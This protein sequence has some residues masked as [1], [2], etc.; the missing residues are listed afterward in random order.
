MVRKKR[1][2]ASGQLVKILLD[3]QEIAKLGVG[4]MERVSISPGSHKIS[5]KISNVLGIGIQADNEAF[6]AEKGKSYFFI[7]DYD[8][9]F[10]TSK[11]SLTPTTKAGFQSVAN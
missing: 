3:G 9:G 1:Y 10:F 11:W 7:A 8:Q 5:A 2:T 4:E 6:V